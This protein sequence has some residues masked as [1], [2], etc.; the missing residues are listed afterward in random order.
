MR[1]VGYSTGA[2][3]SMSTVDEEASTSQLLK[4]MYVLS[5]LFG[6]HN[7]NDLVHLTL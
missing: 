3:A 5:V 7:K 4:E 6:A 2:E 1:N